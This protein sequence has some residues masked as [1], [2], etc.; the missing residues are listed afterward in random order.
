VKTTGKA[1]NLGWANVDFAPAGRETVF[2][3]TKIERGRAPGLSGHKSLVY[4]VYLMNRFISTIYNL[5]IGD[6]C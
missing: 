3:I 1:D 5:V 2:F 4:D 6:D